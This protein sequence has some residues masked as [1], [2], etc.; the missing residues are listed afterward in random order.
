MPRGNR[1]Q[2]SFHSQAPKPWFWF[3]VGFLMGALTVLLL[4]SQ[5]WL[6]WIRK[7][8]AQHKIAAAQS[9][10]TLVEKEASIDQTAPPHFEFYTLLPET[11]VA[12]PKPRQL[13]SQPQSIPQPKVKATPSP[14]TK[15]VSSEIPAEVYVLQ[16]GS[17]RNYAQ[18]NRRK[19][20]LA[21]MGIEAD[22]QTV[23]I[24]SSKTW[25]R[26]R[27]GPITDLS[28]LRQIRQQ[29]HEKQIES[30]LYKVKS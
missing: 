18:A 21:L 30:Q 9:E 13:L 5:D 25:H 2:D 4:P 24:D 7:D 23:T 6:P 10:S 20:K 19:A 14:K 8:S 26:V 12:V 27:I 17:F 16:A 22:I 1:K 3:L 29:L 11:E 28:R 15:P